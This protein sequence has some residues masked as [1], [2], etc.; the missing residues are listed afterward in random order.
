MGNGSPDYLLV[1]DGARF[2]EADLLSRPFAGPSI[3]ERRFPS[4]GIP[5]TISGYPMKG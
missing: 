5:A 3:L 1:S 4:E 2:L